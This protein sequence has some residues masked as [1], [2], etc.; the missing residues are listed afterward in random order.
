MSTR[1]RNGVFRT[2]CG[3]LRDTADESRNTAVTAE[4]GGLKVHARPDGGPILG[5]HQ[6]MVAAGERPPFRDP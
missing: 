1:E 6:L 3:S 5:A 2:G 4:I